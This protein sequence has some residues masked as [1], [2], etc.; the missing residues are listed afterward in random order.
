MDN[1]D[2][3]HK[4][5]EV[6][7]KFKNGKTLYQESAQFNHTVQMLVNGS[8]PY[9]IIEHLIKTTETTQQAFEQYIH[10]DLRPIMVNGDRYEFKP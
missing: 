4:T 3:F 1:L 6:L 10:R 2:R 8:D 7:A 5:N 9:D